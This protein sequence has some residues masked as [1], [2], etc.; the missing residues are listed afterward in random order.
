MSRK[1]GS[2]CTA[3]TAVS[4]PVV[5][6]DRLLETVS[7]RRGVRVWHDRIF[8]LQTKICTSLFGTDWNMNPTALTNR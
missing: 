3:K 4:L 8:A 1:T 5:C 7:T 2:A 6:L